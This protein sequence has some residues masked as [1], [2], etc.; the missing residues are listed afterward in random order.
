MRRFIGFS[1]F[2]VVLCSA[3]MAQQP[4]LPPFVSRLTARV[5]GATIR[6]TWQ[7]PSEPADR[8]L[9]YR[10]VEEITNDSFASATYVGAAGRDEMLFVDYPPDTRDYFYTVVSAD[11]NGEPSKVFVPFRNKT[12][13]AVAVDSE[14]L[15]R[16]LPVAISGIAA[17]IVRNDIVVSYDTSSGKRE[18]SVYRG[19]KP[20]VSAEDLIHAVL[21]DTIPSS[22]KVFQDSPVPGLEYY[23]GLFDS[24]LLR[25]GD[26][27]FLAGENILTSPVTIPLDEMPS[28]TTRS[29]IR[30]RPLPF[31]V[32][33]SKI[34]SGE[35]LSS[36]RQTLET[37]PIPLSP[38][39]ISSLDRIISDDA[40]RPS[41][42]LEPAYLTTDSAESV[43]GD[44]TRF[45]SI[46]AESF[47]D[48]DWKTA[49]ESL[50]LFLLTRRSPEDI[51]KA[52]FYMGQAYYFLH[53][54]EKAFVELL[55][56]SELFYADARP[57]MENVL[58]YLKQL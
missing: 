15:E 57:W 25:V 7:D 38:G 23:Y 43:S 42:F 4:A 50:K 32:L 49:L 11:E 9:V 21:V 52:H 12:T 36:T 3:V 47:R 2:A 53:E 41:L 37:S 16:T 40:G 1:F 45:V 46:I 51:H 20:L 26:E 5:D 13:L 29:T 19:T 31:L 17:K 35:D 56:S 6:L 27:R 8:F 39:V 22:Q 24:E 58:D 54:Y 33:S 18:I 30:S 28:V 34:E 55:L 10:H 44:T 14:S 48:K